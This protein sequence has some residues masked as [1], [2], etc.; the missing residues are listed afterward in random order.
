MPDWGNLRR[1]RPFSKRYGS[2]RGVPID[3]YYL[4]RFLEQRRHLISGRV[5]EIQASDYTRQYGYALIRLDSV[6]IVNTFNATPTYLVDLAKSE[7]VI[8]D[9]TY[10]CFLMP[11][12]LEA[13][14]DIEGC[15][16]NALR[17][18]QPGGVIL[19]S[20]PVFVPL[21]ADSPDYW[22]MSVEG[23]R[24]IAARVWPGCE[25]R[26]EGHGNCLAAVAALLGL[27]VEELEPKELEY[28]DPRYPVLVTVECHKPRRSE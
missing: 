18:V 12:T 5:L 17:V 25:V 23:W 28:Q 4:H 8:P 7:G 10:D 20:C 21:M 26:I 15:L 1:T 22:R 3:R 16:R 11:N 6:D 9:N 24:E 13:L 2:D 19:A 14:Q 27:A